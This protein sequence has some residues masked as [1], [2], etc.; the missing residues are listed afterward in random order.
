MVDQPRNPAATSTTC[1]LPLVE[2][3]YRTPNPPDTWPQVRLDIEYECADPECEGL[4]RDHDAV[5]P[6]SWSWPLAHG[7]GYNGESFPRRRCPRCAH[8]RRAGTPIPELVPCSTSIPMSL[9][10]NGL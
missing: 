4:R 10:S 1:E 2:H 9:S 5:V 6:C 7:K 3:R 8:I